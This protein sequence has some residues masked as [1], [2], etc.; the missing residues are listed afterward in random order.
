[1]RLR[2]LIGVGLVALATLL[3]IGTREAQAV[4]ILSFTAL[5]KGGTLSYGGD[6]GV[7]TGSSI[8]ISDLN[9]DGAPLNNGDYTCV[10]C[11]LS[12]V[13]GINTAEGSSTWTFG[14]SSS[15]FTLV[16]S[17]PSIG[18][19]SVMTLVSGIFTSPTQVVR[20]GSGTTTQLSLASGGTDTKYPGL[21]EYFGIT[22]NNFTFGNTDIAARNVTIDSSTNKFEGRVTSAVV[23]NTQVVPEPT[24][25]GLLG[26]GI[27]VL[28]FVLRRR[29][30]GAG[31]PG[32]IAPS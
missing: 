11:V 10:N 22:T 15:S 32:L 14:S 12:F 31:R 2:C 29:Q 5:N 27:V 28:G 21:L 18:I 4:P 17:I 20:S 26:Y 6:G 19:N 23:Q 9:A 8:I 7:L 3:S 16:G 24:T 25:L 30:S 1:M 13:T